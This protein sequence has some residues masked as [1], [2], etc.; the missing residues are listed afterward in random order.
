[1][2]DWDVLSVVDW[3]I[4]QIRRRGRVRL[5]V[6]PPPLR[7]TQG[8]PMVAYTRLTHRPRV[9]PPSSTPATVTPAYIARR[10]PGHCVYLLRS[11]LVLFPAAMSPLLW[12]R[13]GVLTGLVHSARTWYVW[14][15]PLCSL[16]AAMCEGMSTI[17]VNL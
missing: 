3:R 7:Q 8:T 1:M 4:R 9:P 17:V 2:D 16:I 14:T 5:N 13:F 15:V 11:N 12:T 10:P 6:W